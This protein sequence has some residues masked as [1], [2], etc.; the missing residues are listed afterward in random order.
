MNRGQHL[1]RDRQD[2]EQLIV[3]IK[4]AQVHQHRAAGVGGIGDVHA[5]TG[6]AGQVPDQ[7]GVDRAKERVAGLGGL[8]V[9]GRALLQIRCQC[10][11]A[12]LSR[13]C[14]DAPLGGHLARYGK[15]S[16]QGS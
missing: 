11:Q 8:P 2:L 6:A 9:G 4:R 15:G 5:P 3:P 12:V 7:P 1:A 14:R 13:R 16:K 10:A